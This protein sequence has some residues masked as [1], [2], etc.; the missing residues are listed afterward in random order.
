M[1][2]VFLLTIGLLLLVV[3][4]FAFQGPAVANAVVPMKGSVDVEVT[5][6]PGPSGIQIL[7]HGTGNAT[8]LGS[9][10]VH[11]DILL[12]PQTMT[13]SGT[14]VFTAAN[15][16]Q[17]FTFNSASVSPTGVPDEIRLDETYVITG[18]TGRFENTSGT[19]GG[20]RLVNLAS[21]LS[22]G[23]FSGEINLR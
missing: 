5:R 18:G 7:G 10:S 3:T 6:I 17:L 2:K 14:A 23:T 22:S 12:N 4:G 1:K 19:F 21:G 8:H 13:G 9:Y 20:I 15:G 11:Y 16:D